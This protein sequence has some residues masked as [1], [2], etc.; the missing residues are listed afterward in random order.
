MV[1]RRVGQALALTWRAGPVSATAYLLAM[2]AQGALP[3]GVALLTKW[4]L[5]G[6]QA[7]G[8]PGEPNRAAPVSA[9][10]PPMLLVVGIAVLGILIAVV[11]HVVDYVKARLGRGITLVVQDRL[12]R[13]VNGFDGIR[14]LEDP[15]FLDRLQLAR[16][17]TNAPDQV[18]TSAFTIVQCGVTV[19]GFLGVLLVISPVMASITVVA[20]IPAIFVQLSISGQQALML[21]RISPRSRRRI[22]YQTLLLDLAAVKE[23]RLFGLGKFLSDRMHIETEQVNA[24]E[25]RLDRK[26]LTAQGPLAALSAIVAAG[27]L[28][29]MVSATL[30]GEFTI[31]DVSAFVAAVAG[32]QGALTAMV[33]RA[34]QGYESLLR[35]GHYADVSTMSSDLPSASDPAPLNALHHGLSLDDVW[36]RYTDDGAWVLKGVTMEIPFGRSL[37]L[38]GLNGAGKSTLV[39]L[40]CRLYDPTKGTIRWDGVDIRQVDVTELRDRISAVF[41]DYMSYD[42]TAAENIGI[43]DLRFLND[44][45]RVNAAAREA[46]ADDVIAGLPHGYD[47]M[48][49]R[50][51][52]QGEENNDPEHGVALSGGQWQRLALARA[53]MRVRRDLLIL[54]EPSAGLDPAAE[55]AVHERLRRHREGATSVLISHRLGVVRRADRIVVL[56]DGRVCECG[57]HAE[58]MAADGEYARLFAMQAADYVLE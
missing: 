35:F 32:V 7:S 56:Q 46:G 2:V 49:S 44:R 24:A 28:V 45:H 19:S 6:I 9:D 22:F 42:L 33:S 57:S 58:L 54:D 40:L 34:T 1:L 25:D 26:V 29:W 20:A 14:R 3:A 47:T 48:L 17:A 31:G 55:Q 37:A 41:Q 10:L 38:V 23:I 15:A 11:P 8:A 53:M 52:F 27:G 30:D 21:W 43:G 5:D 50:V 16:Q 18:A 12:Y 39:K 51:F 36:F 4:L 13:A